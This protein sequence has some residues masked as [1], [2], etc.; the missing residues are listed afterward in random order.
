MI[1]IKTNVANPLIQEA[2]AISN[3]VLTNENFWSEFIMRF[4]K[5]MFDSSNVTPFDLRSF[6]FNSDIN[7]EV[8]LYRLPWWK[9]KFSSE[10]AV[11]YPWDKWAINLNQ[12]TINRN[13]ASLC[14][15]IAHEATHLIDNTDTE[16]SFGH[17][18]LKYTKME[19]PYALGIYVEKYL[20]GEFK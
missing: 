3:K 11:F 7:A 8:K 6:F 1:Q 9:R 5:V 4:P 13:Y 17:P 20:M 12:D 15:S 16:R 14:G 10:I 2:V 19:A 18:F